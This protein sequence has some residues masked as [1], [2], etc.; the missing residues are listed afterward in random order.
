LKKILAAAVL[1]TAVFAV[2]AVPALADFSQGNGA[3]AAANWKV[4]TYNSSNQAYFSRVADNLPGGAIGFQ[5][6]ATPDVALFTTSQ[7]QSGLLGDKTGKTVSA[8]FQFS[9][10]PFTYYTPNNPCGVP[11]NVRLYF[12]GNTQGP[13]AYTKYWWSNPASALAVAGPP[14][15]LTVPLNPALWSD[16]NGHVGTDDPAGFNAAVK[17]I[18]QIGLS[19]GGGC[20]FAVGVG[21]P[22]G[23]SFSLSS[24]TV[25]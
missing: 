3:N 17:S 4:Y 5:F 23:G 10:G 8:T 2:G 9:G 20:Y 13:F 25:S 24:Y 14:V 19:F 12:T 22:T 18:D 16:W 1:A 6:P 7:K 15:T 21:A 11:A